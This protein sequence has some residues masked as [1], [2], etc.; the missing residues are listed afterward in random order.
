M[1]TGIEERGAVVGAE[2]ERVAEFGKLEDGDPARYGL[3]RPIGEVV[4]LVDQDAR[5]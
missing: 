5:P 1:L 2:R 4:R 3:V